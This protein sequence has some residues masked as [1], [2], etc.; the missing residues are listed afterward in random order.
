MTMQV[1]SMKVE[2]L[3][4]WLGTPPGSI[5]TLVKP[6][7]ED[8]IARGVAKKYVK[9]KAKM[10]RAPKNRAISAAVNK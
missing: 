10:T 5:E 1:E 7:A 4:T 9:P 3:K 6:K 2:L 8:L